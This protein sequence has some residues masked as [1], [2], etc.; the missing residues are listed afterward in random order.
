LAYQ[1]EL[2]N[3]R[4]WLSYDFLC[5]RV[6]E[7]HYM[8]PYLLRAGIK[9]HEILY[10]LQNNCVPHIAGFNYYITSERYLDDDMSKYPEC[11][12]GGNEYHKYADI[13]TVK[14]PMT[15][16]NGPAVLLREAWEHL[17]IPLAITECHLH[18]TREDQIRWFHTM[19]KTVNQVKEEGADIRAITAWAIFGLTG[20][21][22]LCTQRGGDY[23][24]G[25][26]N[27]STGCPRPTA[28]ARLLQE[29]THHRV[30][31]HPVL[32]NEGWWQRANRQQ[33]G[34][35][36]VVSI[37]R[38][39]KSNCR[40][41]L[42]LGKTGTLGRAF[43]KI[44]DER[45]VH[46]LLLSRADL[47]ITNGTAITQ[48]IGELDPWGVINA[49]GYVNVDEA[50]KDCANCTKAN[51][52]GPVMLARICAEQSVRF[53]TFSSDL[54]FDGTK[55]TPY[56]ESDVANPLNMYGYTKA[57]AEQQVVQINEGALII[58]TSSFFGPW[59]NYNFVVKT[60]AELKENKTVKAAV[61]V[62]VSPTYLPDL[63]HTSLDLL[64]DGDKGIF[65]LA[66]Q[67][68]LSWAQWAEKIALM[69]GC[70]PAL[71]QAHSQSDLKWKA[72]RPHYTV[73]QSERGLQLP[74]LEDA[75][76]RCFEALGN[77]YQTGR[78]AV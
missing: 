78:I 14:V 24:P 33:Y 12:H 66:N 74:A 22:R 71:V 42:I 65:H 51:T 8:W 20:W 45:N 37:R 2:E 32:E 75:L 60:L 61:D 70:D 7:Q 46:H 9:P 38:K 40:P 47:D 64:L 56:V 18:S 11:Y 49:A 73:L 3:H 30:Y 23:E 31:Y 25:V 26:F 58:R 4:R 10:F 68:A 19:W 53:L 54:V 59:D 39:K 44:C 41:L 34:V 52:D 62:I 35:T 76:E 16:E 69:A 48:L 6:N 1:A 57:M 43:S 27:V 13:E 36:K 63:V 5:G 55:E 67:G 50:E 77:T 17:Q 21:N 29:L 15:E 72:K 28:L